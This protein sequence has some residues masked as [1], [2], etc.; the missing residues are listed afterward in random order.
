MKL[1]IPFCIPFVHDPR[2]A[3]RLTRPLLRLPFVREVS[4][5][6]FRRRAIR[7]MR[8][9]EVKPLYERGCDLE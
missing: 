9:D 6:V 7:H 8:S 1:S 4:V 5:P 2:T 3:A